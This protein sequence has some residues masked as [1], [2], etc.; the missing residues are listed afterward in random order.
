MSADSDNPP[1]ANKLRAQKAHFA[2]AKQQPSDN[3]T[4]DEPDAP[5][6]IKRPVQSAGTAAAATPANPP[7]ND[8]ANTFIEHGK[9]FSR[10]GLYK[11][12][13]DFFT[14]AA[15]ADPKNAQAYNLRARAE[16]QQEMNKESLEDADW[17][18]KLNP[19]YAEAFCTRAAIHNSLSQYQD[20][21]ADTSMAQDLNPNL[22]DAYLLQAVAY[23]NLGQHHEADEV[24]AKMNNAAASQSAFDEAQLNIDYTPYLTYLQQT[25]RQSWTAPQGAYG[26]AVAVFKIH[27]DGKITDLRLNNT[28]GD[29][30]ADNS[31][32]NAVRR[33]VPFRQ[34][35]AGVPPDFD[36]YVV[37]EP[38]VTTPGP[39]GSPAVQSP[40]VGQFNALNGALYQGLGIMR[41]YIPVW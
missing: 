27:R 32:L 36:V 2:T 35:P 37:L 26:S 31:A 19:D 15:D 16:W 28:T 6:R 24:I 40:G 29:R 30:N 41:R 21:V 5:V 7:A 13:T 34:P 38:P 14:R 11:E 23:R 39:T 1:A 25:V 9:T 8:P 4:S 22:R 12:A 3:K 18:I 20:A 10:H 17:A 33:C